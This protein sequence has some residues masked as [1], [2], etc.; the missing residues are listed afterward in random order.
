M[1]VT[2][3]IEQIDKDQKEKSYWF[4]RHIIEYI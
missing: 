1:K 2:D 3:W 4:L